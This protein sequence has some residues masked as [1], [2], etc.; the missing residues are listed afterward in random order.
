M[1]RQPASGHQRGGL[2]EERELIEPVAAAGDQQRWAGDRRAAGEIESVLGVNR[3]GQVAQ[4][5]G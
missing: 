5:V 1:Q 2:L 3:G 4:V